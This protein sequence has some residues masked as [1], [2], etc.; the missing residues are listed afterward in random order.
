[1]L[2]SPKKAM[3]EHSPTPAHTVATEHLTH[4]TQHGRP[5]RA[6]KSRQEGKIFS[7]GGILARIRL[8]SPP[9]AAHIDHHRRGDHHNADASVTAHREF[10]LAEG[11]FE[12]ADGGFYRAAPVGPI[13][14]CL[15]TLASECNIDILLTHAKAAFGGPFQGAGGALVE[16]GA[17][18]ADGGIKAG[19]ETGVGLSGGDLNGLT[20]RAGYP[21]RMMILIH[22]P[23][24]VR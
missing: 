19:D 24:E 12:R 5:H 6:D 15:A 11:V 13:L 4:P 17:T 2:T 16:Q 22:L 20:L 21:L 18:L 9:D 23:R 3:S 14:G 1:M 10:A 8:L 7:T